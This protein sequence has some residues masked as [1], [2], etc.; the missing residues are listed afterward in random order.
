M[1]RQNWLYKWSVYAL[2]LLPVWWLDAYILS[3]YPLFG[4]SPMLL[5]V[6]AAAVGVLEG[7]AGGA[8]FGLGAGLL[9]AMAYPGAEGIRVFL[10]TLIGMCTGM[11]SQYALAQT[12]LG[13]M[14]CSAG[15]L[16]VIEGLNVFRELFFLRAQLDTLLRVAVPQLLWSLCWVPP[17]YGLFHRVFRRVG[18]NRLA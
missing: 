6:A 16:A 13:C 10:L 12:L 2:A 7:I 17:V 11:V 5:P 9:W 1:T 15:A 18:G 3:R 4:V 14:L 8:G